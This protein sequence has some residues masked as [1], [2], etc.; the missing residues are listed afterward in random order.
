[1]KINTFIIWNIEGNNKI[2]QIHTINLIQWNQ[3]THLGW[4]KKIQQT[5]IIILSHSLKMNMTNDR[6]NNRRKKQWLQTVDYNNCADR[7]MWFESRVQRNRIFS[8][9]NS[10]PQSDT[11][12]ID[13]D[14]D[15][16]GLSIIPSG[17][18]VGKTWT[19]IIESHLSNHFSLYIVVVLCLVG[20]IQHWLKIITLV[21]FAN[22]HI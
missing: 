15:D 19:I 3:F 4:F 5:G 20:F 7:R 14:F 22:A 1:M 12:Y 8:T 9:I 18:R 13:W 16:F 11:K 21:C 10:L 6:S 17:L 2:H